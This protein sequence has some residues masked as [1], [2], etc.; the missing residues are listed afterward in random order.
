MIKK[1]K[2]KKLIN[3]L[4]VCWYGVCIDF[5]GQWA[6]LDSAIERAQFIIRLAMNLS[7]LVAVGLLIYGGIT[8]IMAGGDPEQIEKGTNIIRDAM[9]GLVVILIASVI[10]RFVIGSI[11]GA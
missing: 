6:S 4:P 8:F 10:I 7:G 3:S 5:G 1:L 9:I 11:I 2:D